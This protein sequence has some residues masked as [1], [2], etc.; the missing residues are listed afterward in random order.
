MKTRIATLSAILSCNTAVAGDWYMGFGIGG[1]VATDAEANVQQIVSARQSLGYNSVYS[2]REGS[3]TASALAGYRVNPYIDIEGAYDYLGRFVLRGALIGG[4]ETNK[5]SAISFSSVLSYPFA[6]RYGVFGRL[7]IA[8]VQNREACM[9]NGAPQGTTCA[10]RSD[11][12]LSPT[13]GAGVTINSDVRIE[14]Q[15]FNSVGKKDHEYT[16]G[17]FGVLQVSFLHH[18]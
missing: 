13:Y 5:V 1:N 17:D 16:A 2:Y 12:G 7:G 8:A 14:Y 9:P 11:I 3:V 4:S 10:S 6:G 15:A 18:F